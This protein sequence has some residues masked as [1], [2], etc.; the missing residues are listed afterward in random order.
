M[1]EYVIDPDIGKIID[2]IGGELE[3]KT[4]NEEETEDEYI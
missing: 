4:E 3:P 1:E 2:K